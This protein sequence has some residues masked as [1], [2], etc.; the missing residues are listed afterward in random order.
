MPPDFGSMTSFGSEH[1]WPN[2]G[3]AGGRR[4]PQGRIMLQKL[5]G[6]QADNKDQH[7]SAAS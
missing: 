6:V 4:P 1:L 3:H 7:R 2:R 5:T